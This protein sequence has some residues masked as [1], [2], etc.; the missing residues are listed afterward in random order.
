MSGLR[1]PVRNW[2][3]D[4]AVTGT[5]EGRSGEVTGR[6]ATTPAE[7]VAAAYLAAQAV[8]GTLWWVALTTSTTVRG[9]FEL[10]P[11]EAQ[12]MDAFAFADVIVVAGSALGAWGILAGKRWTAAVLWFT[13][14]AIVYPTVYLFGW[15]SFTSEGGL[16]LG[17][18]LVVATFTCWIA[19]H[20]GRARRS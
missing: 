19:F 13:A 9:W 14:G 7:K 18:M 11:G 15:L 10:M 12:V 2:G 17:H 1:R 8:L 20:V 3:H 4:G 6:P 5:R 16:L